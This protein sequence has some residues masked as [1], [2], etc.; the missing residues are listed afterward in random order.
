[1]EE[2]ECEIV[3]V[4]NESPK[5]EN[6]LEALTKYKLKQQEQQQHTMETKAGPSKGNVILNDSPA[7]SVKGEVSNETSKGRKGKKLSLEKQSSVKPLVT[8]KS[9][10]TAI[11]V[12]QYKN[13]RNRLLMK[14][15]QN[16]AKSE[17]KLHLENDFE[18]G[19]T[20]YISQG[21]GFS[22]DIN[23][24]CSDFQV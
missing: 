17:N 19:I 2:Q 23:H 9:Q 7:L 22:A 11:N 6:I 15:M 13:K 21:R 12:K 16:A 3:F 5:K 1:M 20:E 14:Y 4:S 18:I 24:S 10:F 8:R